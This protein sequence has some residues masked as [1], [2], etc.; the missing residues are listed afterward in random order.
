MT[1]GLSARHEGSTYWR[2]IPPCLR[3]SLILALWHVGQ[4]RLHICSLY[5][6][7]HENTVHHIREACI[8]A[9]Q[10]S[11]CKVAN[12][13]K[14]NRIIKTK[15]SLLVMS[16]PRSSQS[17][18]QNNLTYNTTQA[19]TNTMPP[20]MMLTPGP[21]MT[22]PPVKVGTGGT[23]VLFGEAPVLCGEAPVLCGGAPA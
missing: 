9:G 7:S 14:H 23:P 20:N 10:S 2:T 1:A 15:A 17:R 18:K 21:F 4:A 5:S 8:R 16:L 19:N 6:S 11:H 3:Q 12:N 13:P 22:E